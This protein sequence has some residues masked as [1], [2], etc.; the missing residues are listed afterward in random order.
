MKYA[1]WIALLILALAAWHHARQSRV[2]HKPEP[3]LQPTGPA[4]SPA[5]ESDAASMPVDRRF[6]RLNDPALTVQD[7]LRLVSSAFRNYRMFTKDASGNP[8]GTHK[9]IV[10]TLLGQNRAGLAFLPAVHPAM[11]ADGELCDRW[12]TPFF[13]HSLSSER[14]EIRSAGPDRTLW[15]DD[16][17]VFDPAAQPNDLPLKRDSSASR[18]SP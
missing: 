11:N 2:P 16:D 4:D 1:I 18:L 12:G 14:M 9:E 17:A 8:A 10:R 6:E 15:T 3:E 13:F 5:Y 7:D